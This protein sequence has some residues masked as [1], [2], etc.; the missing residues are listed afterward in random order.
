VLS[1]LGSIPLCLGTAH[2]ADDY[3]TVDQLRKALADRDNAIATMQQQIK[4]LQSQLSRAGQAAPS[5][6]VAR[7]TSPPV[8]EQAQSSAGEG[9]KIGAQTGAPGSEAELQELSR[10]L[11]RSLVLTGGLLLPK[12]TPEL[13]PSLSYNYASTSGLQI[14]P[15]GQNT[16][17][18]FAQDIRTHFLTYNTTF[19][20]GLPWASQVQLDVPVN[21]ESAQLNTAGVSRSKSAAGLDDIQ[22]TL[23][24]QF[25]QDRDWQPGLIG[26]V[27]YRAP[28]A[29]NNLINL[30]NSLGSASTLGFP[31]VGIGFTAVKRHDPLV[32]FG[33]Y[34]HSFNFSEQRRGIEVTPGDTDGFNLGGIF[35]VSPDVSLRTQFEVS[36]TGD[37]KAAGTTL[38]GSGFTTGIVSF[39]GSVALSNSTLLDVVLGAGVTSSS[40]DF[41][42]TVSLPIRY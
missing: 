28:T 19:R 34:T 8:P 38:A 16:S 1:F 42:A 35:A 32:F 39:G 6:S 2:A 31:G 26:S 29:S 5:P 11:E 9:A 7:P 22:V 18:I 41:T 23:S 36:Y 25:L 12:W 21:Y 40:P 10:A 13:Q 3:V 4:E 30:E 24:K 15:T 33:G 20:L 17:T 27:S 14:A 37:F